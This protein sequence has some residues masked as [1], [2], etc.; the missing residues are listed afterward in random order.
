[1]EITHDFAA[2][3]IR[4]SNNEWFMDLFTRMCIQVNLFLIYFSR[5]Q[6]KID[7]KCKQEISIER[8]CNYSSTITLPNIFMEWKSNLS[9]RQICEEAPW[10]N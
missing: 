1:M 7:V 2:N 8:K 6:S 9:Q 4:K 10:Y 5:Q 3:I